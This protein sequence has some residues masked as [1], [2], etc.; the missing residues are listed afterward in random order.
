MGASPMGSGQDNT[1]YNTT[2]DVICEVCE[3]ELA[4]AVLWVGGPHLED[5]DRG[6]GGLWGVV[7][8]GKCLQMKAEKL[9]K[10]AYQVAG[11]E[12]PFNFARDFCAPVERRKISASLRWKTLKASG[13]KCSSCGCGGDQTPLVVDHIIPIAE[14]GRSIPENLQVLCRNCNAGKSATDPRTETVSG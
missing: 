7:V 1:E 14:G 13:Y 10:R 3:E 6:S 12:W 2:E 5:I 9:F 4:D 11:T 8:C